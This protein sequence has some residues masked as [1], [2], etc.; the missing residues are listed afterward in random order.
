MAPRTAS[1]NPKGK[2]SAHC[3]GPGPATP[4]VFQPR[5]PRPIN[6]E[7]LDPSETLGQNF[8]VHVSEFHR[9]FMSMPYP[10]TFLKDHMPALV[11]LL[12]ALTF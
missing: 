11:W 5:A 3:S 9:P 12:W 6:P 1:S 8:R 4:V 2:V 7:V 10:Y